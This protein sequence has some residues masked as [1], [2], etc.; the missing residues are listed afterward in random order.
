MMN[1][2][3][4]EQFF[5]KLAENNLLSARALSICKKCDLFSLSLILEF[6]NKYGSF[7][8]IQDCGHKT[9]IELIEFCEKNKLQNSFFE[10]EKINIC[11]TFDALTPKKLSI[12]NFCLE[13]HFSKLSLRTKK[14]LELFLKASNTKHFLEALFEH[15]IEFD[16][17]P[18]IGNFTVNEIKSFKIQIKIYLDKLIALSESLSDIEIANFI[19]RSHFKN[20]SDENGAEFEIP[21]DRNGK[22]KLFTLLEWLIQSDN[23][24]TV[25]EKCIFKYFYRNVNATQ[26]PLEGV[27]NDL[28]L[29]KINAV[30]LKHDLSDN[31]EKYFHFVSIFSPNTFRN[32]KIEEG[33]SFFCI[34]NTFTNYLNQLEGVNFNIQ[35]YSIVFSLLF[36]Q[37]HSNIGIDKPLQDNVKLFRHTF[38]FGYIISND[39]YKYFDFGA[40]VK[41]IIFQINTYHFE[42]YEINFDR[43]L[44][45]F[46]NKEKKHLLNIIKPICATIIFN[47][48][49]LE[50][51]KDEH[52]I[53]KINSKLTLKSCIIKILKSQGCD[54]KIEYLCSVL[55]EKY[56][57]L[58]INE[59]SVIST[60]RNEKI[61]F[62][63]N[64]R[65]QICGLKSWVT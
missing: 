46:L 42:T 22:I 28:N 32:Y 34:E 9:D 51:N 29:N 35:F 30:R 45:M 23:I 38:T 31:L 12:F 55:H 6:Y 21:V 50:L 64:Y 19:L 10:M 36:K 49:G 41:N 11:H 20:I 1:F 63:Y 43:V 7:K 56:P 58:D 54:M 53:F 47:E 3:E 17:F 61:D 26:D 5:D 37:T 40:F 52:L 4:K 13:S 25:K 48:F 16:K 27:M 44:M 2:D 24:F 65:K 57:L 39:L 59:N 62:N 60:V 14:T 8:K 15:G 18:K 33:G